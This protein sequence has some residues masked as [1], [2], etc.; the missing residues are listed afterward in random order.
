MIKQLALMALLI[1]NVSLLSAQLYPQYAAYRSEEDKKFNFYQRQAKQHAKQQHYRRAAVNAARAIAIA[2]KKKQIVKTGELLAEVYPLAINESKKSINKFKSQLKSADIDRQVALQY[3]I[4]RIYR[5]LNHAIAVY[6]ELPA[7]KQTS[8]VSTEPFHKELDR[9]MTKLTA[10]KKEA[11]NFHYQNALALPASEHW[12]IQLAR[13]RALKLALKYDQNNPDIKTEHAAAQQTG[14]VIVGVEPI[15][16]QTIFRPEQQADLLPQSV[17]ANALRSKGF[18]FARLAKSGEAPDVIARFSITGLQFSPLRKDQTETE[19]KKI[20]DKKTEQVARGTLTTYNQSIY[21]DLTYDFVLI[22]V[23]SQDILKSN[24]NV[25]NDV[26]VFGDSWY[27][28][29]GDQRALSNSEKRNVQQDNRPE[30]VPAEA[31]LFSEALNTA[32]QQTSVH[33]LEFCDL[34]GW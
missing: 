34:I 4:W 26:L 29:Q 5:E 1:C 31:T 17:V 21:A 2:D 9:A 28:Y 19:R 32:R 24:S 10:A 14:Q 15:I 6:Q 3:E 20:I 22:D 13:A 23:A 25:I 27:K 33:T 16:N 8:D 7:A 12:E 30:R 18:T 11:A